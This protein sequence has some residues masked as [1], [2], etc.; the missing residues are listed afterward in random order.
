MTGKWYGKRHRNAGGERHSEC[1]CNI[2]FSISDVAFK[3][4]V[5][6]QISLYA[7]HFNKRVKEI[8]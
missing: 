3:L 8:R 5:V 6:F 4:S 2:A 1:L 7:Y